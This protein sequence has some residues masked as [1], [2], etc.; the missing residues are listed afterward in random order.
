MRP[1]W[2]RLNREYDIAIPS[3]CLGPYQKIRGCWKKDKPNFQTLDWVLS[4]RGAE[5]KH[6]W[7]GICIAK[8]S[9]KWHPLWS[10][11]FEQT[12]LTVS[13]PPLFASSSFASNIKYC[14]FALLSTWLK[15]NLKIPNVE[16]SADFIFWMDGYIYISWLTCKVKPLQSGIQIRIRRNTRMMYFVFCSIF[17][18]HIVEFMKRP[19]ST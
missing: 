13:E 3:R 8:Y 10:T 15:L 12:V 16:F 5:W 7:N 6:V 18:F 1:I 9:C 11:I 14:W 19:K 4:L 17:E 2:W